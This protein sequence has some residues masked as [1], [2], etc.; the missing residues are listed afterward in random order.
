MPHH[1]LPA[2]YVKLYRSVLQ[3]PVFANGDLLRLWLWC[4][5]RAAFKPTT[6]AMRTGRGRTEVLLKRG[7]MLFG[8]YTCAGELGIAPSTAQRQ[9]TK[10]ERMGC[11]KRYPKAHYTL[12]KVLHYN[13]YQAAGALLRL[14]PI[15]KQLYI[16]SISLRKKARH[17]GSYWVPRMLNGWRLPVRPIM[18]LVNQGNW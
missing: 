4:L 10:L 5:L 7:E 15:H 11:I 1:D 16:P 2:G 12:V 8:R 17:W 9:L 3:H 18:L 14:P 13:E 6:I